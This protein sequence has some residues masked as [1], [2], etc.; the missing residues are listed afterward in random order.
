MENLELKYIVTKIKNSLDDPKRMEE[1]E[2]E[3]SVNL[4]E[5]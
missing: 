5:Q 3:K 2:R 1:T 4:I